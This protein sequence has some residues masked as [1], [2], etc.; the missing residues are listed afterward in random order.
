MKRGDK[1]WEGGE[2]CGGKKGGMGLLKGGGFYVKNKCV[3][4]ELRSTLGLV[5]A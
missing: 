3:W 5:R 2:G 1:I 4:L